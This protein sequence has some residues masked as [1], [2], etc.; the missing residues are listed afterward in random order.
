MPCEIIGNYICNGVNI[1]F[2]QIYSSLR[3]VLAREICSLRFAAQYK[4]LLRKYCGRTARP[5]LRRANGDILAD[6]ASSLYIS[7]P[8]LAGK[9][10]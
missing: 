6:I 3:A 7:P 5:A 9:L 4:K 8:V 10:S 2:A 1:I